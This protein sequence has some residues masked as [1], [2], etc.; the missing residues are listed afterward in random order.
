[1]ARASEAFYEEGGERQDELVHAPLLGNLEAERF[2]LQQDAAAALA[3]GWPR[4]RVLEEF[5]V[6]PPE[7]AKP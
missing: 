5:G 1:M 6:L 4:E 2:A 3:A 7:P